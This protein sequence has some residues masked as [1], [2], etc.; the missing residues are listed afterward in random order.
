M[1]LN[2]TIDLSDETI[3]KIA[4][5]VGGT[6]STK[7]TSRNL[8]ESDIRSI[9]KMMAFHQKRIGIDTENTD[10]ILCYIENISYKSKRN[11]KL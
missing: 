10:K 9:R 2:L 8:T 6:D 3:G 5:A 7:N 4:A 11:G 1:K